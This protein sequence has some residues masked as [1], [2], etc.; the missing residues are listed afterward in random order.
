[1]NKPITGFSKLSKEEKITWLSETY[2]KNATSS[3]EILRKYWNADPVLQQLHDEFTENTLS[4]FYLPFGIAPNFLI[5]SKFLAVPMVVEESSVIAAASK[6]AKFWADHGGFKATV[7]GTKKTGHVH[8]IYEGDESHLISFF[9]HCKPKL[10]AAVSPLVQNMEK[11]GGGVLDI[12][13]QNKT[14]KLPHYYQLY[15]TFETKDAMGAN[16]I[17]S[18]LE[19]FGRTLEEEAQEF[20]RFSAKEKGLHVIMSIL[21]N[22]VPE[23][24]VRAEVSCPVEKLSISKSMSGAEF[25]EKFIQAVQIAEVEPARAVTHNKGI[26]NGI[27]AVVLA[28]G[29]DFRAVEAGIHAFAAKDGS[30]S[31]LTHAKVENGIF[32]CWIEIPIAL[33]T[34]GGL[35]NLHP[36]VKTALEILQQPTAKELMEITAAAGLAQNFAAIKSLITTGIQQGHMKMHL[37]NILNQYNTNKAEKAA[38]TAHFTTHKISHSAVATALQKWRNEH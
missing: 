25:A 24:L 29:N 7:L 32:T 17:N 1:M 14:E 18:C 16:F 26:M 15:C 5:N 6:S 30:Y 34:V 23:C 9:E 27:D 20:P 35:T 28:T 4:N 13:L 8:F 21:S 2:L 12:E 38:M 37:M 10:L 22:Y 19:E 33:G 3:V 36:M 31:S 11:R